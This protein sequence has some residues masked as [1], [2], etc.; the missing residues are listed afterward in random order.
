[1][2]K[3]ILLGLMGL[4]SFSIYAQ[5]TAQKER[6]ARAAARKE[7]RQTQKTQTGVNDPQANE[8]LNKARTKLKSSNAVKL[9]F[10]Y[11]L[12]NKKEKIKDTKK[13]DVLMQ[14]DKYVLNFMGMQI[15]CDG[16]TVWNYNASSKEVQISEA[17]VGKA[18]ESNP[19]KVIDNYE[20]DFRAKF[21]RDKN[22]KGTTVAV[23]DL[24]PVKDRNFY[25]IRMEIDMKSYNVLSSEIYD[26]SGST[27]EYVITKQTTPAVSDKDFRFDPKSVSGV[28]VIDLR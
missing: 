18:A 23:I 3:I 28:E 11:V 19:L 12:E 25:K 1:M 15:Y 2:K 22:E 16:K 10:N 4:I 24:T 5:N 21:I 14:G 6:Q 13:G 27:F 17:E 26:K 7:K 8:I 20:K 9:E